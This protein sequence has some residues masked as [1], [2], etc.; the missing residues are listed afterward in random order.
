MTQ[1]RVKSSQLHQ[2]KSSMVLAIQKPSKATAM[3]SSQRADLHQAK[4][5]QTPATG[6]LLCYGTQKEQISSCRFGLA[7]VNWRMPGIKVIR[8]REKDA[9]GMKVKAEV[10]RAPM[11]HPDV[12]ATA[13]LH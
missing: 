10:C 5:E 1:D 2:K 4:T 13:G 12:S 9:D 3:G 6:S 11:E 8:Y 7:D